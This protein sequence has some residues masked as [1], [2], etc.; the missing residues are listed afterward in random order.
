[1]E[2]PTL[3]LQEAFTLKDTPRR[4]PP[5]SRE[6]GLARAMVSGE[7][8]MVPVVR[9]HALQTRIDRHERWCD[10]NVKSGTAK[11]WSR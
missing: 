11:R 1:M 10:E 6:V 2:E 9:S 4:R 8:L 7:Y 5:A 3:D